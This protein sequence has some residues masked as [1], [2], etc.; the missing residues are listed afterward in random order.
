MHT[1]EPIVPEPSSFEVEITV[2]KYKRCKL[3]STDQ[4]LL[5]F[6]Q[7]GGKALCSEI[8]KVIHSV[9]NKEEQLQHWKWS[10]FVPVCEKGDKTDYSNYQGI[11]LPSTSYRILCSDFLSRLRDH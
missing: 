6:I 2:E 4:I 9:W 8:K 5:D 10:I 11:S 3:P 7:A 1:T